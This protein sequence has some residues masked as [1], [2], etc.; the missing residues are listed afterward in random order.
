MGRRGSWVEAGAGETG[1]GSPL[2]L[3]ADR[4]MRPVQVHCTTARRKLGTVERSR[5]QFAQA[6]GR[7]AG[8]PVHEQ[9]G[10]TVLQQELPAAPARRQGETVSSRH[11]DGNEPA[12]AASYE[13]G[14]K[15]ALAAE[16]Q[17]ERSV[18]DIACRHHLAVLA[19]PGCPGSQARIGRIRTSGDSICGLA[20]PVPIRHHRS[21]Q[22]LFGSGFPRRPRQRWVSSSRHAVRLA[23][24]K[25][26]AGQQG[27]QVDRPGIAGRD[28]GSSRR[29]YTPQAVAQAPQPPVV[30][31][32]GDVMVDVIVRP[33]GPF[34]RGS[35]TSSR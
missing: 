22:G 16:G 8:A 14:D 34:N 29:R 2:A 24:R 30:V 31:V 1:A 17:P 6:L 5:E 10:P 33:L 11:T 19:Q 18:L 15:P 9:V 23:T 25:R 21:R 20:E 3:L 28:V 7:G 12:V 35:D 26:P 32:V 27:G 4:P 13:R